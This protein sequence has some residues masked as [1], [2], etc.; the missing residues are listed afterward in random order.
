MNNPPKVSVCIPVLNGAATIAETLMSL[1]AQSFKDLEIVIVDNASTDGT[2]M[3]V[4][5]F[6][7]CKTR[8]V[9]NLITVSMERNV[10]VAI[11]EARGEFIAVYHADDLYHSDIIERQVDYL[12]RHPA[13]SA[14]FSCG[15]RMDS[16]G[17]NC[18]DYPA[19]K[20]VFE[21]GGKN[22]EYD[23]IKIFKLILREY[24]FLICPTAM[25]RAD[26]YKNPP[27]PWSHPAFNSSADLGVWLGLL[28]N[29]PIGILPDKLIRVRQ[30]VNQYSSK[31]R[32]FNTE[33]AD[34]FRVID[35]YINL[36]WVRMRLDDSDLRTL[37]LCEHKD[38]CLRAINWMIKGNSE[39][40]LR[41]LN[42]FDSIILRSILLDAPIYKLTRYR[43]WWIIGLLLNI[44]ARF[45]DSDI[46]VKLLEKFWY[47]RG[48]L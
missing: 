6:L 43:K 21:I 14:V 27:R 34:F 33:R 7:D 41:I 4:A 36:P 38:C 44:I 48:Y 31:V 9:Q 8:L 19:P 16:L 46:K 47:G 24:N 40:G 45:P 39:M 25:V 32:R 29:N 1:K 42:T 30:S 18:G 23:F 28:E 35:Y 37:V 26:L 20:E 10:E 2:R 11:A 12:N 3:I 5:P 22:R 13:A 15:E 17:G